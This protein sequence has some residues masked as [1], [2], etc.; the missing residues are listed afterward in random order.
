MASERDQSKWLFREPRSDADGYVFCFPYAGAGASS[1]RQWPTSVGDLSVVPIQP[2]GR[3]NRFSE[4]SYETHAEYA[5]DLG[6]RLA[7]FDTENYVLFAHC[8]GVPFA[9]ETALWLDE[10]AKPSPAAIVASSW[11]PPQVDLYGGLNKVDIES[12][13][14][15]A[16]VREVQAGLGNP[17]MPAEM[18]AIGGRVLRQEVVVHRPWLYDAARKI[19]CRTIVVGWSADDVVPPNEATDAA[20]LECGDVEIKTLEGSHWEFADCPSSLQE[21]ILSAVR[22]G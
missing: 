14:F 18:A 6:E 3:E 15:A 4:P 12:H 13:D 8:G 10:N 22:Q 11:G 16:E 17:D 20:W 7:A 2:P 21:V 9:L 19:P 5:A 1:Y